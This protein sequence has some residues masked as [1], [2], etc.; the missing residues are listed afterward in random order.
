M[1]A[2]MLTLLVSAAPLFP[3]SFVPP[4]GWVGKTPPPGSPVDY[5]WLSPHYGVDGNG[6]NLSV[7]SRAAAPGT[8]LTSEV[9]EA[10]AQLSQGRTIANSHSESTCHGRL[11]G[12]TFAER[13]PLP[14]SIT[15]EQISHLAIVNGRVYSFVLTHKAGDPVAPAV[16]RSIHTICPPAKSA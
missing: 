8:T 16:A 2:V 4:A 15:I 1:L 5:V 10:I 6:E 9:H 13:M 3:A 14:N 7:T 12:W 11:A